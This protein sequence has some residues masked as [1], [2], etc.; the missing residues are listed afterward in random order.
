MA[1]TPPPETPTV[2]LPPGVDLVPGLEF[3]VEVWKRR[4]DGTEYFTGETWTAVMGEV[5][6]VPADDRDRDAQ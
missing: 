6:E 3:R 4:P 1:E 2:E 5:Q